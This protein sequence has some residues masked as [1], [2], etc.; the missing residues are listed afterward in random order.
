[1]HC[2]ERVHLAIVTTDREEVQY[3]LRGV[4]TGECCEAKENETRKVLGSINQQGGY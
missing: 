3:E 2:E 1:M 4:T